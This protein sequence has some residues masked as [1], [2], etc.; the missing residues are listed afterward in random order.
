MAEDKNLIAIAD[1]EPIL[2]VTLDP[3]C[4]AFQHDGLRF[5]DGHAR[6]VPVW[7]PRGSASA[8][9]DLPRGAARPYRLET[10]VRVQPSP[11]PERHA[12]CK[13]SSSL[14]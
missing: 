8:P 4:N 2:R 6:S 5:A 10:V 9:V 13:A 7:P 1:R 3:A 14:T 11:W 12:P